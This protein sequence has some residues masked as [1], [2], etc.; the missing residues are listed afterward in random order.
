MTTD[1]DAKANELNRLYDLLW[2][3]RSELDQ[4]L[5]RAK[6]RMVSAELAKIEMV[7]SNNQL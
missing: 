3:S 4:A 1:R 2:Q 7:D 5:A 6:I